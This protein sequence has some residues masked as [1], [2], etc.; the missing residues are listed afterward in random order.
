MMLNV[1]SIR[2]VR[3]GFLTP[4]VDQNDYIA[5]RNFANAIMESH[6]VLFTHASDFQLFRIGEFDT[7]KGVLV[8]APVH[9][10]VSDGA[11][12]FRAMK[13]EEANV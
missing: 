7:D 11:E 4:T 5:A 10:L 1:Y 2:D 13:K 8:P 3:S 9:E 6:G 12:V